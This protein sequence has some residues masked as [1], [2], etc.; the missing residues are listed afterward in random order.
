MRIR[1]NS[2]FPLSD[3]PMVMGKRSLFFKVDH[4]S[5]RSSIHSYSGGN[6]WRPVVHHLANLEGRQ[7]TLQ[8]RLLT[9]SEFVGALIYDKFQEFNTSTLYLKDPSCL[10]LVS[11]ERQPFLNLRANYALYWYRIGLTREPEERMLEDGSSYDHGRLGMEIA[12]SVL[13]CEGN[14]KN[15]VI[16]EPSKGGKDL[17]LLTA[18]T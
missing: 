15:F 8:V 12:Y 4:E 9:S 14:G 10:Y 18:R 1:M 17:T 6:F 11:S 13:K 16:P 3:N 7:E 2:L 5:E